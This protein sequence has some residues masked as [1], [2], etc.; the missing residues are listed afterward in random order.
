MVKV[1]GTKNFEINKLLDSNFKTVTKI[2]PS[3]SLLVRKQANG[4]VTF[5]WRYSVGKKSE[6]VF[7][8][9]FDSYSPPKSLKPTQ[10]GYSIAAAVRAAEELAINHY[11]N[12]FIGGRPTVLANLLHAKQTAD[13]A[14][15]QA[16]K[17]TL[18]NLL[19]EYSNYLEKLAR[20]S[21]RETRSIFSLHIYDPWPEVA[22]LQANKVN[23]EQIA[24]MMRKTAEQGKGRTSNKL[25][26][27]VRAAYEVAKASRSKASIPSHFKS[28]NIL[29]NP[30]ADTTPDESQNRAD[31]NPL[32]IEELRVYWRAIRDLNTFR[33]AVL[34]LHLLTGG[35][36]IEQLVRLQTCKIVENSIILRDIKGR[37][38]KPS[39]A[40]SVPLTAKAEA[41]LS[42][43]KPGSGFALSTD[44]GKTHLAATTLSK[45]AKEAAG[46]IKNFSAKRIRS[47]VETLLSK[48]GLSREIRGHLQSHGISGIQ[49]IHYDANDFMPEKLTALEILFHTIDK[50]E[51]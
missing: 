47:G 25:R 13:E 32:T 42:D 11:E 21:H 12:R 46:E 20:V 4:S 34:R 16:S 49:S 51:K 15:R 48:K 22:A 10:K 33:G 17:H 9:L 5:H 6:R 7:I 50:A 27:Y 2:R 19:N 8:G 37:P 41:A 40:H 1:V 45:W 28:Y 3:G 24:D 30:A 43:C 36:R 38:G 14:S 31:K 26:S 44:E 29:T 18:R 23:S 39:R 35:Q